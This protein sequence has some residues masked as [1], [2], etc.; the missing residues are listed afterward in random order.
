L[1]E[2]SKEEIVQSGSG[3]NLEVEYKDKKQANPETTKE[4]K[5]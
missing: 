5:T 4:L 1:F 2:G 3:S